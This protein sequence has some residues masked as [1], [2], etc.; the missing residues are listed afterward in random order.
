[1]RLAG[2]I[3][4]A[5]AALAL[6]D[7]MVN[8]Y[9]VAL[10]RPYTAAVDLLPLWLGA[11]A[12]IDGTDPQ[13]TIFAAANFRQEAMKMRVGGFFNYY[14]PTASLFLMPP[15]L[16]DVSYREVVPPVRVA[17]VVAQAVGIALAAAASSPRGRGAW[18][19]AVALTLTTLVMSTRV[20]RIVIPTAQPGSLVVL[21]AGVGLYAL[22]RGRGLLAGVVIAFG[23]AIKLAPIALVLGL[24]QARRFRDGAVLA[25]VLLGLVALVVATGAPF[26]VVRWV[27]GLREFVDQPVLVSRAAR[28]D[29]ALLWLAQQRIVL[30]AVATAIV[31]L[32]GMFAPPEPRLGAAV[33]AVALGAVALAMAGSH[34]EHEA[35]LVL[36]VL[37]Y[38]AAWPLAEPRSPVAITAAIAM[39]G[40][41]VF[42]DAFRLLVAPDGLRWVGIAW[43]VF[44]GAWVRAAGMAREGWVASRRPPAS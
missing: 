28:E 30:P 40:A 23:A 4:A 2:Q 15:R 6:A 13:D 43:V 14:P 22:S 17:M 31:A 33:G 3:A 8:V 16:L 39:V 7:L 12:L 24:L 26:D 11:K 20:S 44:T 21:A 32:L 42:G 37:A 9:A 5:L 27:S 1:M 35:L 10:A 25:S 19:L 36:P 18:T 34:H 38:V 29:P 41:L